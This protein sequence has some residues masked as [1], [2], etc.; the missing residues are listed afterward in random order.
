MQQ[1]CP[2]KR[3]QSHT[4][5]LPSLH[6][7]E[8]RLLFVT[9][10]GRDTRR[11]RLGA[12]ARECAVNFPRSASH[13]TKPLTK[14]YT[15]TSHDIHTRNSTVQLFCVCYELILRFSH[16][17]PAQLK[18][19]LTSSKHTLPTLSFIA[20][21]CKN[22][23]KNS[24]WIEV[25]NDVIEQFPFVQTVQVFICDCDGTFCLGIWVCQ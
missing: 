9:M 15:R 10:M 2:G 22:K 7:W 4:V 3:T 20:Y 17:V 13:P 19:K 18:Q 21:N 8:N 23:T 12:D 24:L 16:L 11:C 14:K 5:P 6:Q 1:V 25:H